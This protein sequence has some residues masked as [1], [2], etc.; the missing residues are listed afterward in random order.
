MRADPIIKK[1]I[2]LGWVVSSIATI[3]ANLLVA[4]WMLSS[5]VE[6]GKALKDEVSELQVRVK[7]MEERMYILNGKR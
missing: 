2:S 7:V 1:D 6:Q 4:T 3:V 5:I